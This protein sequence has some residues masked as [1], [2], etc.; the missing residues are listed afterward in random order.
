MK[1]QWLIVSAMAFFGLSAS[2]IAQEK[3][4]EK[5]EEV[6]VTA[7]KFALKKENTGK[8]I[9]KITQEELKQQAGK[10]V[11]E[12]LNNVPGIEIRNTQTAPGEPRST[13]VRGGRS[14]QVL[15][16]IDGVPVTD[17]TGI[18]QA[19][20]LRLLS[21]NM[22][23]SIEVLKGSSSTLYGTGAGA[24]VINIILKKAN[25][26]IISA[27]YEVTAGSNASAN[28]TNGDLKDFNQNLS[29]SGTSG[30]VSYHTYFSLTG[31]DGISAARSNTDTEFESDP[32]YS[33]NGFTR[34]GYQIT[35]RFSVE[36]FFNYDQFDYS[37]DAGAYNDNDINN[38]EQSQIR[39]GIKPKFNYSK[40][41][42][43]V[44]AS[45]NEL[46][47]TLES[48]NAWTSAVD[49]FEYNGKSINVDLVNKYEFTKQLQ[50]ITGVNYQEHDNESISPFTNI[51]PEIANFNVVDPYA[52]LVYISD[53]GL[54][55]NLG[56]RLNIH[57]NYGNHF[58]Y[59]ANL[60]FA[61]F[62]NENLDLKLISSYST[63]FIAPSLYQL[64]SVFGNQDLDPQSNRTYEF[65]FESTISNILTV[66]AVYFDRLEEDKIIFQSLSQAP[67]GVYANAANDIDVSGVEVDLT[68]DI[69]KTIS[70]ILGYT[71][72]D[73]SEDTD[74]IPKNKLFAGLNIT[75]SENLSLAL[76]YKNVGERTYFD[77][78]GSFGNAGETVVL[79]SYNLFDI[80]TNY[81]LTKKITVF[82]S[83]TN[84][85]NE[86]YEETLGYN[87]RG[88]NYKLGLRLQF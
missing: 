61:A 65:G 66:N 75:P 29:I 57:S 59:D 6:V 42:L 74:Y 41:E 87:T 51:D 12:V 34:V 36:G 84:L 63:A 26:N 76:A 68:Y 45:I 81:Q 73:K 53:F 24:G 78:Y 20:D 22:I 49:L 40:G 30:K 47:R 79:P 2:V 46:K 31:V 44:L 52:S 19:Y 58:V 13:Y 9:H 69:S 39:Y 28:K 55:V 80:N 4:R 85:F 43:Y 16:L 25:K 88:R 60:A 72:V 3:D 38:G 37:Y 14:S 11:I 82:G 10:T 33:K 35:D 70:A 27:T 50:L 5:L 48:F 67:W 62:K 8:V 7:T 56:S 21:L 54:S 83:V 18:E 32:Y 1:K 17:P 77:Q 71:Y 86:D 23:E 15:I 64:F